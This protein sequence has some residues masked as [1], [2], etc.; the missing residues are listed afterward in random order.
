MQ[1]TGRLMHRFKNSAFGLRS[2]DPFFELR[3]T[4]GGY[5]PL[6]TRSRSGY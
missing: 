2:A 6:Y 5:D 4:D 3:Y 1:I